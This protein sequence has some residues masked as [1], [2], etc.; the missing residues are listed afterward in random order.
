M[1]STDYASLHGVDHFVLNEAEITLPQFLND[2][3][4]GNPEYVYRT[5]QFTDITR[6]PV[7][8]WE[9]LDMKKYATMDIQ[10]S[11][12]CPYNC[13]FCS[14][15]AYLGRRPRMKNTNQF[16]RELDHLYSLGWRSGV[17]IVDDNFIANR[18]IVKNELLPALA[19]WLREHNYPFS[20]H[21]EVTIDLADDKE[22]LKLMSEAGF[23]MVFV[24]SASRSCSVFDSS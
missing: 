5:D 10:Y 21:T 12:G 20:F 4:N 14:I 3:T 2:L 6:T 8:Q 24:C 9:L 19:T 15:T 17:F 23:K 16:L 11:R 13:E 7:P 18:K 1:C 22:L